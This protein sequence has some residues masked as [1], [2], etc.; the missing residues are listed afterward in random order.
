MERYVKRGKKFIHIGEGML[1]RKRDLLLNELDANIGSA[2]GIQQAQMKAKQLM[3]R[4]SGV[5]SASV[6]AGKADNQKD[7][8]SGE[9]L[10]LKIP[11]NATGNELAQAKRMTQDQ[12]AD[13][14]VIKFTKDDETEN[15][16]DVSESRIYEMRRNSIP[17]TKSEL[18]K[19]LR[20]L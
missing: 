3:N 12:G 7:N 14:A 13:D 8:S 4:N 6:E 17:F 11:V 9:G 16:D 1:V 20:R 18:T 2:N 19:F 5:D 15:S 10:E